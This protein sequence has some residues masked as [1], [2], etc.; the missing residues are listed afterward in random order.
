MHYLDLILYVGEDFELLFTIS[1]ENLEKLPIDCKVIG[2]VTDSDVVE[3]SVTEME[4]QVESDAV[5]ESEADEIFDELIFEE[6]IVEPDVPVAETKITGATVALG[7]SITINYYATLEDA[8]AGAKMRFTVEDKTIVVSGVKEGDEYVY[9]FTGIG[10]QAMGVNIKA[11]L[12]LDGEVLAS[13]DEYSVEQNLK[14]LLGKSAEA[15]GLTTGKYEAM[16]TLIADLLAYG[17]ASQIYVDYNT[18]ALVNAGVEGASALK[19]LGDEWNKLPTESTD[20]TIDLIS[21]GLFF[22]NTNK[23]YFLFKAEGI[24]ENN[25]KVKVNNEEYTL[26]DFEAYESNYVLFT[27]DIVATELDTVYTVELVK[28]GETVQTLEYGVYAYIY[29]MQNSDN[30]A[31]ATLVKTLYNYS[32]SA[33]AYA[34][35]R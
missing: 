34:I 3:I 28:N 12:V 20:E 18:D 7:S 4:E 30:E 35:A 8:H 11:E 1:K 16:K 26:S 2:E 29:D 24:T 15:L 25:F 17:A 23:L 5:F 6:E 13:K 22:T 33:D 21:A 10:P 9:A 19:T 27:D 31:M 14:N 32:V